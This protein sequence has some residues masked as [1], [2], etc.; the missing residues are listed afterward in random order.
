MTTPAVNKAKILEIAIKQVETCLDYRKPR[1]TQIAKYEDM[2][3]GKTKPAAKGRFNIPV[4][5]LEG[6]VQTLE[7]KI[8][9]SIRVKF[10]KTREATLKISKKFNAAWGRDS[11]PDRGDYNGADLDAKKLA[12]FSG[13]GTLKLL[14]TSDPEYKQELVAVDYYDLI[15]EPYG[16]R[17]MERHL[18]KG[19]LNIFKTKYELQNGDY[20][21]TEVNK[22]IVAAGE[23]DTKKVQDELDAKTNRYLAMGLNP[24]NYNYTGV[25]TFNLTELV[26]RY[27]GVDYYILFNYEKR[28]AVKCVPLTELYPDGFSPWVTWH[29][30]RSPVNFLGRAPVDSVYPVAEAMR[31]LINQNFDNIQKRNWDMVLYNAKKVIDPREFEYRPNGLIRLKLADNESIDTA[32]RKMETPDTSG[33]TINLIQFLNNFLGEKTGVTPG[34][35]GNAEEEKVGIYYGNIQQAADRFGLLNKFYVQSHIDIAKRY[36]ANLLEYAPAKGL[37]VRY[38]GLTGLKEEPLTRKEMQED[39]GI[40]VV[41]ANIEAQNDRMTRDKQSAALTDILNSEVLLGQTNPKTLLE[42]RLRLGE[43]SEDRIRDFLEKEEGVNAELLSEAAMAIEM[44]EDGEE[45]KVNQGANTA[46]IRK[47]VRHAL[48]E[49]DRLDNNTFARLMRY[50]NAHMEIAMRN[51]KIITQLAPEQPRLALPGQQQ[52]VQTP[53]APN[54]P[55]MAQ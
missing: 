32:Y 17:D 47:I 26:T 54:Q 29:T 18:F 7:S 24:K 12:I 30:E 15:F 16:G 51:A 28:I 31:V 41:S 45:P 52:P 34:A 8:D 5:I 37:M 25:D 13:F 2:Y 35:Q 38:L 42:E 6:F 48:D 53:I 46:F 9:D 3:L 4:P 19:Q 10:K 40:E 50:A 14:P 55:V 39:L 11:A 44:I 43:F 27:E 33:I 1:Y 21:Q 36:K 49:S 20:D 23:A 22:L